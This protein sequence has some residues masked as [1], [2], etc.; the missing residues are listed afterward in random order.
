[1]VDLSL[2]VDVSGSIGWR[3]P[4]VQDAARMFIDSFD[5]TS[6]RLSLVLFSNGASVEYPMPAGRGF[7]KDVLKAEVPNSLPGGSTAMV[8]GLYRGWDELRSVPTGSAVRPARHRAVHRRRVEQRARQSGRA[9]RQDSRAAC[10]PATSRTARAPIPTTR[11][12][13]PRRSTGLYNT[14]AA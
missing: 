10:A 9:W 14:N 1:M 3:W 8:Q 13:T 11:R 7:D 2:I 12:T 4:Y 6:D 5:E